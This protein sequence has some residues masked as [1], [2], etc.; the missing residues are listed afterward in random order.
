MRKIMIPVLCAL[1]L[2]P[3]ASAGEVPKYV[4]LTFDD[5]PSG[6]FTQRLL[7]GLE[8]RNARATFFLCGYRL[9]Q[10]PD[11]AEQILAGGHEIGLHGY[12]HRDLD[13]MSRR[14]IAEELSG[15][16]ALLPKNCRPRFL[17]PPQGRCSQPVCQ[18]AQATGLSLLHWSVDPRDWAQKDSAAIC[19]SIVRQVRDGDVILMHDM[20]DAS[21][22]AALNAVDLLQ[23]EG[24]RF[25]TASELA[26]L[27]RW[28]IDPGK[29]YTSFPKKEEPQNCPAGSFPGGTFSFVTL[30]YTKV[31][32]HSPFLCN[33]LKLVFFGI[34]TLLL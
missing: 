3:R 8:A 19:R 31:F 26:R 15:T 14:D 12:S 2:C 9:A 27:H 21:V 23:K 11:L 4:A 28:R 5:G 7:E 24:F 25:V 32:C 30:Y 18:V 16:Q 10:Y 13:T 17:R 20:S 6:R 33:P 1:L 22:D 29:C 34:C